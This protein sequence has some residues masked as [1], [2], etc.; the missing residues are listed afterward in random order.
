M[1]AGRPIADYQPLVTL[2]AG[3]MATVQVARH[4]AAGGVERLVVI[5]RVHAH[6]LAQRE[7]CDMFLDEGRIASLIRHPNVVPVTDAVERDGE[8]FLILDY[9]ESVTLADLLKHARDAGEMLPADV[10][11]RIVADL[12]AGLH[13][14][15]ETTDLQGLPLDVVHRD[16]SPGNV[17]VA[18]D[19]TSHLI[20]FGIAKASSRMTRT[21]S[22]VVK[23]KFAYMAPEQIKQQTPDRRADVFSAAVV[24]YQALTERMP[25]RG[26]TD[27]DTLLRVL[28]SEV[29]DPSSL[30][31]DLPREIDV[32]VQRGLAR[33]RDE[34]FATAAEFRD[35]LERA[36]APAPATAVAAAVERLV[37]TTLEERRRTLREALAKA[38][39]EAA[40]EKPAR[41]P[42][43]RTLAIVVAGVAIV[44]IGG[45]V[46]LAQRR[47]HATNAAPPAPPA[48][49]LAAAIDTATATQ[50]DEPSA[51]AA[52]P[53]PSAS[54]PA[55]SA[56]LRPPAHGAGRKPRVPAADP[57]LRKSP[58]AQ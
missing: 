35:A 22:G 15:H 51:T 3:G 54:A 13:A 6:L 53:P 57:L 14:A 19:G 48:P 8:M 52:A 46:V 26:D 28:V 40:S 49:A 42:V 31:A 18:T 36:L 47:A 2:G 34:R 21:D 44:A 39:D 41:R 4:A 38:R 23:G 29:P 45:A 56:T 16:V 58:Y 20:D 32:V 5:K 11:V 7:F 43:R 27:A 30:R 25:F 33:D 24:L 50:S 37:G 10:V 17:L 12:L 9:V 55:P 1:D